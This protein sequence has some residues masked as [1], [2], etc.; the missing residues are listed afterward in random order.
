MFSDKNE[1]FYVASHKVFLDMVIF[2][3]GA[4]CTLFKKLF[5]P[6]RLF[7]LESVSPCTVIRD[8][9]VRKSHI[10]IELN[11]IIPSLTKII[12]LKIRFLKERKSNDL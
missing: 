2:F 4:T 6:V 12:T 3:W 5:R 10:F 8:I 1:P 11:Q 7:F 9:R